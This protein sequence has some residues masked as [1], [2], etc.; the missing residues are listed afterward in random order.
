MKLWLGYILSVYLIV[1]AIIPCSFF[2]HCEDEVKTT[3]QDCGNEEEHECKNCS[4]FSICSP[5]HVFFARAA[6]YAANLNTAI[7]ELN[8]SH[9]IAGLVSGYHPT[10]LQPPRC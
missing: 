5:Q 4:P 3:F 7:Y 2:D 1:S 6:N 10:L 8:Y 9:F